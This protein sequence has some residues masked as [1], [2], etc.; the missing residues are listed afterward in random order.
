MTR[1]TE[2]RHELRE[3][4]AVRIRTPPPTDGAARFILDAHSPVNAVQEA[5][6]CLALAASAMAGGVVAPGDAGFPFPKT[7]RRLRA[8]VEALGAGRDAF[9]RAVL[10]RGSSSADLLEIGASGVMDHPEAREWALTFREVDKIVTTRVAELLDRWE[11]ERAVSTFSEDEVL[12]MLRGVFDAVAR[13]SRKDPAPYKVAYRPEEKGPGDYLLDFKLAG[14][15][16]SPNVTMPEILRDVI[17]DLACNARKYSSPGSLIAVRVKE[18]RD[19]LVL[20]VED[21]G[22]GISLFEFSRLGEAGFRGAAASRR[23]SGHG[24]GLAKALAVASAW[25]GAV[26]FRSLPDVGT[27]FYVRIPKPYAARRREAEAPDARA[28]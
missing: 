4:P 26:E 18:G 19:E 15:D 16:G 28:R 11:N 23:K 5:E 27:V 1:A 13:M 20:E 6:A 21:Q 25:G 22:I 10:A 8:L 14:P 7:Q 9:R 3:I 12:G 24:F 17:R 2:R